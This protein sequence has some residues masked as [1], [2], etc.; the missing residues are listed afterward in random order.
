MKTRMKLLEVV[1]EAYKAMFGLEKYI[2]GTELSK[3]HK[4]LIKNKGITSKWLRFL[5]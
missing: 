5:Y 2:N 3:I 4:Y 1:P